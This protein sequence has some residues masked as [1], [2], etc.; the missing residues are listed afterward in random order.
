MMIVIIM[1]VRYEF[2]PFHSVKYCVP[3]T[4]WE[5]TYHIIQVL[6]NTNDDTYRALL[7]RVQ[8]SLKWFLF[9]QQYT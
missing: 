5:L 8:F 3:G 7:S 9:I 4:Y 1:H 6:T 2:D